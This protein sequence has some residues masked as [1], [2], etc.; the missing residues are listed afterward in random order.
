[1][2]GVEV[3]VGVGFKADAGV[4]VTV[5][6]LHTSFI[7][8]FMYKCRSAAHVVLLTTTAVIDLGRNENWLNCMRLHI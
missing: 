7:H 2:G 8:P 1:M 4:V 3:E 5:I 6:T